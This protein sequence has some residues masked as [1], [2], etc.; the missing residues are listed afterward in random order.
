MKMTNLIPLASINTCPANKREEQCDIYVRFEESGYE[1][2]I[3][4]IRLKAA[5]QVQG[6]AVVQDIESGAKLQVVMV[7]DKPLVFASAGDF[8]AYEK[9]TAQEVEAMLSNTNIKMILR[10]PQ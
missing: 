4:S 5:L 2:V 3:G 8:E 7:D 6:R 1:V 9:M 10:K